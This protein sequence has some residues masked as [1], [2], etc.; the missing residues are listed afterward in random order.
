MPI[1]SGDLR[2][3]AA[4]PRSLRAY[5]CK[6]NPVKTSTH[7][8]TRGS[9]TNCISDWATRTAARSRKDALSRR[10]STIC[11][12]SSRIQ[13][14]RGRL[15]LAGDAAHIVPPAGAKGL[16]LAAADV[17]VLAHAL[18]DFFRTGSTERLERYSE[19]CLIRV[20]KIVR[21]SNFLTSLLHRFDSHTPFDRRVQLSELDYLANSK[22]AQ[23]T[24]AENYVGL[25]LAEG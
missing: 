24:V 3:R 11:A 14:S 8:R 16:N 1:T 22:A 6:Q 23:V 19:T 17:R 15:F 12:R 2:W 21:F 4:D 18:I 9:G 5:T 7:G 25:P 13:C 10:A 20:W